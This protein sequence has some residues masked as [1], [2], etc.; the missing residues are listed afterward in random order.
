MHAA[1]TNAGRAAGLEIWR[2]EV[3]DFLILFY[4]YQR[5]NFF[6]SYWGFMY[7]QSCDLN[8]LKT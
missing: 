4:I 7:H 2:I 1:F 8:K 5:R 3:R 6:F